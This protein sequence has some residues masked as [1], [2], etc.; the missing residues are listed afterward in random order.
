M[1]QCRIEQIMYLKNIPRKDAE[2]CGSLKINNINKNQ[3]EINDNHTRPDRRTTS[4]GSEVQFWTAFS[5]RFIFVN[6][7]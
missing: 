6:F 1:Q 4:G 5:L 7:L 2:G 3:R